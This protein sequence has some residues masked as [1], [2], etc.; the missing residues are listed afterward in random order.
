MRSG[1]HPCS[2]MP[3]P[4]PQGDAGC[5]ALCIGTG[6][7]PGAERVARPVWGWLRS[8]GAP[9]SGGDRGV[10]RGVDLHADLR[11]GDLVV[12]ALGLQRRQ[13]G[14]VL[15]RRGARARQGGAPRPGSASLGAVRAARS[16]RSSSLGHPIHSQHEGACPKSSRTRPQAAVRAPQALGACSQCRC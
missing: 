14:R 6:P 9:A 4:R 2:N 10:E 16:Q 15:L 12:V 5:P 8:A 11:G 7:C 3:A 13:L 1:R